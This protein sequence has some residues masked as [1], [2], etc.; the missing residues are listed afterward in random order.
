MFGQ[1]TAKFVLAIEDGLSYM[2]VLSELASL[3]TYM[4]YSVIA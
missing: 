4:P 3:S 1:D 2:S